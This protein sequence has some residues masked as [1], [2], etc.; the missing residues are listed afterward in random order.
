MNNL[1]VDIDVSEDIT[2]ITVVNYRGDTVA[3]VTLP[4]EHK[5]EFTA[6]DF[7]LDLRGVF[8]P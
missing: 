5:S 6:S 2:D 1:P 8:H 3:D 7:I 4:P